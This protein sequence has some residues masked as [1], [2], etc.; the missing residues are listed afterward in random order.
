MLNKYK[1]MAKTSFFILILFGI[2]IVAVTVEATAI[3]AL[4]TPSQGKSLSELLIFALSLTT[5]LLTALMS[6]LKPVAR[7]QQMREACSCIESAIWLFRTRTGEYQHS[8]ASDVASVAALKAKVLEYRDQIMAAANVQETALY[9]VYP[10]G[11]FIHHQRPSKA[12]SSSRN[13]QAPIQHEEK[14]TSMIDLEDAR[15]PS[16]GFPDDHHS[17]VKPDDYIRL[18]LYPMMVLHACMRVR[19]QRHSVTPAHALRVTYTWTQPHANA[20]GQT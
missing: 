10:S 3:D 8:S 18:R 1:Q 14:E 5:T 7:W 17:P 12:N 9:K 11:I 4:A 2:S 20:D 13:R 16:P 6:W 19:R 15:G